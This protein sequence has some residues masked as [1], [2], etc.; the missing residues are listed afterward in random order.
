MR[1]T[2]LAIAALL[3]PVGAFASGE[4]DAPKP[5]FTKDIAPIFQERCESCHRPDNMPASRQ[6]ARIEAHRSPK[7]GQVS[8]ED[9]AGVAHDQHRATFGREPVG[10]RRTDVGYRHK[11]RR[12]SV[13]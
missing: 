9:A 1:G 4:A 6:D 13:S 2:W 7:P 5:T 10:R 11:N 12:F 8:G 3:V